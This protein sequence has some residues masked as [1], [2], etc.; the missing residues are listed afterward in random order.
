M[1]VIHNSTIGAVSSYQFYVNGVKNRWPKVNVSARS[2]GLELVAFA[3]ILR[4]ITRAAVTRFGNGP[5]ISRLSPP[6]A[7]LFSL[8]LR[9]V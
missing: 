3:P 9:N 1:T 5:R 2:L 8:L 7:V 4:T 6:F